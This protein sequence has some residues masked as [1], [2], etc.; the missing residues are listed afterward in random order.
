ME[1]SFELYRFPYQRRESDSGRRRT[2]ARTSATGGFTLVELLVVI[3]II[4]ILIALLLPAVQMAR[5]AARRAD[6]TN[7]L[8]QMGL[9]TSNFESA[10]RHFPPGRKKPDYE[11][12]DTGQELATSSN[13]Y[14][15]PGRPYLRFNN[16]SVHVWILPYMEES[17]VYDLI[18]FELGQWKRM[19]DSSGTPVNPHYDAYAT[20]AGLFICPSDPNTGAVISENNYRCNF[21]GSTP[22]AGYSFGDPNFDPNRASADGFPAGG[23]GAFTYSDKGLR[24]RDMTDGLSNTVFFSERTKGSGEALGSDA[25]QWSIVGLGQGND[26]TSL[27]VNGLMQS[28]EN[29]SG[30]TYGA[31]HGA[32]RWPD[33]DEWSNGWPFAGYDATEYNHVAP[34]NWKGVDCGSNS[35]IPDVAYEHAIIAARSEHPGVVNVTYGD[36]HV[37]AVSE[38]IDLNVWRALGTRNG[39]EPVSEEL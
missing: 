32:G 22:F 20:A 27:T 17:N 13:Y 3:A 30:S 15:G 37:S 18:D 28:C 33:G 12:K 31:F 1:N 25:D 29:Y 21:G 19:V 23:N 11:N 26:V 24:P 38:S 5:E 2:A 4:G 36:G 8:K 34:P 35:Y 14:G 7:N 10:M 6:C 39:G 16:F 9:A